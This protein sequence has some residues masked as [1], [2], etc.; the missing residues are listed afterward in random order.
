MTPKRHHYLIQQ[1]DQGFPLV[2]GMGWGEKGL[3]DAFKKVTAP[4]G[5]A[6]VRSCAGFLP[7]L[8]PTPQ[9]TETERQEPSSARDATQER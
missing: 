7:A 2:P 6:V 5:V 3:D 8:S 4:A 9:S 1:L